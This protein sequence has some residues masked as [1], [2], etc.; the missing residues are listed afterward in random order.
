VIGGEDGGHRDQ[1]P[2]VVVSG[3]TVVADELEESDELDESLDVLGAVV[4]GVLGAVVVGVLDVVVG[5]C[6]VVPVEAALVVGCAMSTAT[7]LANP[8]N[9]AAA[10]TALLRLSIRSRA[11]RSAAARAA[12]VVIVPPALWGL[13]VR[14]DCADRL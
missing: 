3:T 5:L 13:A 6:T 4:V 9:P 8:P 7:R 1:L 2:C 11:R 12:G 14:A 10:A